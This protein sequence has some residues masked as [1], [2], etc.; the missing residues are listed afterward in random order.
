MCRIDV[1]LKAHFGRHTFGATRADKDVAID[2]AKAT[3]SPRQK[4]AMRQTS[5]ANKV[6]NLEMK[7]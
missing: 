2:R 7:E 6:L 3:W 5:A 4:R 1:N